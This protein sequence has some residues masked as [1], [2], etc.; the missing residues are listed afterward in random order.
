[1]DHNR[2]RHIHADPA[3][4]TP[5]EIQGLAEAAYAFA[6]T[7]HKKNLRDEFAAEAMA[8]LI[9]TLDAKLR[10]DVL[11]GTTGGARISKASYMY[12]DAMM[13]ARGQ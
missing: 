12:A 3:S 2:I 1:M 10:E 4:A 9:S 8:A 11:E 6:R 5:A 7:Q 13:K